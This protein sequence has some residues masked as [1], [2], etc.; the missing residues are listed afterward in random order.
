MVAPIATGTS[1]ELAGLSER[2]QQTLER[3]LHGLA[4]KQIAKELSISVHTVHVY[5]KQLYKTFRVNSRGELLSLWLRPDLLVVDFVSNQSGSTP[6]HAARETLLKALRKERETLLKRIA[7]ID[8][9]IA[10]AIKRLQR[11]GRLSK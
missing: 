7:Y 5:V 1:L 11:Y 10:T 2:K 8:R 4:E 9:R 6:V 3:L